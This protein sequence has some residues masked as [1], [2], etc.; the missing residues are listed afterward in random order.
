MFAPENIIHPELFYQERKIK[1]LINS[2]RSINTQSSLSLRALDLLCI[3]DQRKARL[4]I[5]IGCGT[6][7]T[8]NALMLKKNFSLG[9]DIINEMIKIISKKKRK[10]LDFILLDLE[11]FSLPFR[12]NKID[13]FISISVFQ[14]VK[15]SNI[16]K[17][18]R[19]TILEFW[20]KTRKNGKS[21]I[22]FYPYG[23]EQLKNIYEIF[24]KDSTENFLIIDNLNKKKKMKL[25]ILIKN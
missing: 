24:G 14:W 20:S 23:H 10:G 3:P 15:I 1:E 5:D 18:S 13:F 4:F 16:I 22:Q 21:I 17:K 12:G 11:S 6:G 8:Q 2:N 25:F 7:L 19:K 9:V